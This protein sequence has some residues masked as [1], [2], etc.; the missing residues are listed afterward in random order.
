[1]THIV[2]NGNAYSD[3]GSASRDM[4]QG[5]YRLW[6]L[7]MVGDQMQEVRDIGQSATGAAAAAVA[8]SDSAMGYRNEAQAARTQAQGARTGAEAARDV[9]VSARDETTAARDVA[10]DAAQTATAVGPGWTPVLALRD[11][12][13]RRVAQVIDFTGGVGAKPAALIGMYLGA[14]GFVA[15]P[16]EATDLR[17]PQ[18]PAGEGAVIRPEAAPA[19]GVDT[20]PAGQALGVYCLLEGWGL[21]VWRDTSMAAPDRECVIAPA[22]GGAGRWHLV[23]PAWD[24]VWSRLAPAVWGLQDAIDDV[25][26]VP[27]QV[28]ADLLAAHAQIAALQGAAAALQGAVQALTPLRAQ[29]LL[30]FPAIASGRS[31]ALAV[32]LPGATAGDAV[33][34]GPPASLPAGMLATAHVSAAGTVTVTVLNTTAA[35]IDPAAMT[36]TVTIVKGG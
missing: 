26:A 1:M 29:A 31:A 13:I 17:G 8:A 16:D 24:L 34:L 35:T 30:D 15:D 10:V 27:A 28:Q 11:I 6:L 4:R 2:V 5:G 12:D 20:L 32:A 36:Y 19:Q 3:D 21:Y 9:A 18:G 25:N 22:G 14:D 33:A 23:L 7:P